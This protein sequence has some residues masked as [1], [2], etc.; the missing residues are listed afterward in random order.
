MALVVPEEIIKE[1]ITTMDDRILHVL[2]SHYDKVSNNQG[3]IFRFAVKT[4]DKN[5]YSGTEWDKFEGKM[6]DVLVNAII[7][8]IDGI[9]KKEFSGLTKYGIFEDEIK[10]NSKIIYPQGNYSLEIDVDFNGQK[11]NDVLY[12]IIYEDSTSF[13]NHPISNAGI[14]QHATSGSL[15]TL[16]GSNS[17][18]PDDTI[19]FYPWTQTSGT[20]ITLS[21]NETVNLTFT[22]PDVVDTFVFELLVNDGRKDSLKSDSVDITSLHSDAGIDQSESIGLI[23]LDGSNSGDALGHTIT[24]SWEII[25]V[26]NTSTITT[27]DLSDSTS[28]NPTFTPDLIGDYIIQLDVNDG[29]IIDIDTVTITIS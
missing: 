16:D 9:V 12:F 29:S 13:N 19:L 15:V 14:D 7:K 25:E 3:E 20:S 8:D 1:K 27:S 22:V 17:T 4:F 6:D 26:P 2:T 11:F 28:I 10:I 21:D 24:Y 23:T 18:D 5:V